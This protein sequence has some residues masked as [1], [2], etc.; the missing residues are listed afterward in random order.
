[1]NFEDLKNPELQEKLMAV[2]SVEEL[3][4]LAKAE[5]MELSDDQLESVSGGD[6]EWYCYC[7]Q[8]TA[9]SCYGYDDRC[10]GNR[11]PAPRS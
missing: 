3:V 9:Y 4:A 6:N 1:M 2:E 11:R 10:S 8:P 7:N 5:G